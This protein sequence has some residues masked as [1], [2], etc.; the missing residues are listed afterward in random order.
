MGILYLLLV[1]GRESQVSGSLSPTSYELGLSVLKELKE[2]SLLLEKLVVC[3]SHQFPVQ[4][5]SINVI[6]QLHQLL[7][8]LMF[9]THVVLNNKSLLQLPVNYL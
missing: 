4:L 7:F 5:N 9:K 3:H 6:H 8:K 1:S 2:F